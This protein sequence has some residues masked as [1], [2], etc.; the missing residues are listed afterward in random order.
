[1]LP[2]ALLCACATY[3]PVRVDDDFGQSVH[4]MISNQIYDAS[5]PGARS[6]S[7]PRGIDGVQA[8]ALLK[9]QR[10]GVGNPKDVELPIDVTIQQ[11]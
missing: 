4:Q 2:A 3:D 10:E 1:L 11:H 7:A 9:K 6:V 5:A 8:E